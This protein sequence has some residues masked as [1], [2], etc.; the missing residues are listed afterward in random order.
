MSHKCPCNAGQLCYVPHPSNHINSTGFWNSWSGGQV[1]HV[2][3]KPMAK[4]CCGLDSA[5][6]Y[7]GEMPIIKEVTACILCALCNM[8]FHYCYVSIDKIHAGSYGH[9]RFCRE[10]TVT[11]P[12][13]Q[14]S[15]TS[16]MI[17]QRENHSSP[18]L[19]CVCWPL[20]YVLAYKS[21]QA[22][23][24]KENSCGNANKREWS[25]TNRKT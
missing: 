15:V 16:N 23:M 6:L 17:F 9:K 7:V 14:I 5:H 13:G 24:P 12:P 18:L 20:W 10:L 19:E 8:A 2:K 21:L 1:H 11:F 25:G 3:W 4:W 22:H